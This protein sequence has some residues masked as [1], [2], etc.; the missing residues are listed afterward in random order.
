MKNYLVLQVLGEQDVKINGESIKNEIDG[1]D[2][3]QIEK[4]YQRLQ[5]RIKQVDC[6][7]LE[8]LNSKLDESDCNVYW[9]I[10]LTKYLY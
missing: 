10:I 7:L 5:K 4:N 1:H 2:F 9:G 6:P 3:K 8:E